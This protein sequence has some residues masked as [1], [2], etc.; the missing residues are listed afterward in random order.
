[1]IEVLTERPTA[2]PTVRHLYLF[3]IVALLEVADRLA[4]PRA[5]DALARGAARVAHALSWKKRRFAEHSVTR[6]LGPLPR[7]ERSRIVRGMFYTFWD[8]V[9]GLVPRRWRGMPES[10]VTGLPHLQA[11]L[12][13]GKGVVLWESA[14]FGRRNVAM[15]V[16]RRLGFAVHQVHHALHRAG[17]AADSRSGWLRDRVVLPALAARDRALVED[18]IVLPLSS[19]L[20]FTRTLLGV[21]QR[22]EILG[23]T[24]DVAYG[25]RLVTLPL[26]GEP[27]RFTTGMVSLARSSGAALLPL[28]CTR[29]P[30]GRL[31]VTIEPAIPVGATSDREADLEAPLRAYV[32]I[33][34]RH[35]RRHPEQYRDWHYPWWAWT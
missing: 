4:S 33:L 15:Q 16:L 9:F 31:H 13:A 28:F 24:A 18:V 11:A 34:E 10:E 3:A 26:F 19:S 5:L 21:L 20:A 30:D 6:V 12:A 14:H 29:D 1:V 27:K 23:V 17:F 32:K 22:N 2:Y 8:E 35:L 25:E 7:A